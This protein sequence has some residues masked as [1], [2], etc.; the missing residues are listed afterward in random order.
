MGDLF[1]SLPRS[2]GAGQG[3]EQHMKELIK[4]RR[5]LAG[6]RLPPERELAER[7]NVSRPTL[8]GALQSLADQGVLTGRQGAGWVVEPS[9]EVVAANLAVYLQ[10]EEVTF[11]QLFTARRAVEPHIAAGAARHRN[12]EQ[13]KALKKSIKAMRATTDSAVYL[14]ADSDFHAMLATASQNPVFS[15]LITPTLNLLQDVRKRLS[16]MPIVIS[17]SHDEH[18]QIL[19]AVERADPAAAHDAMLHH[20]DRFV[21]SSERELSAGQDKTTV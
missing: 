17:A 14:Q 13:I 9:G 20:I 10:L 2:R 5:L 4:A 7:L 21:A 16:A 12:A 15:M 11:E 1:V 18:D 8:R 6:D 3:V 19:A